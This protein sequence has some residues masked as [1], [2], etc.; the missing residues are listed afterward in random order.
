[1]GWWL[2]KVGKVG[3]LVKVRVPL[4]LVVACAA[5]VVAVACAVYERVGKRVSK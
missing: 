4:T 2:G 3:G 1:M 5:V